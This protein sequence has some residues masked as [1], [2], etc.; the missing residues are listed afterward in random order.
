MGTCKFALSVLIVPEK[1]FRKMQLIS[2]SR[3]CVRYLFAVTMFKSYACHT[4]EQTVLSF[5]FLIIAMREIFWCSEESG[6]RERE[7]MTLSKT[8]QGQLPMEYNYVK[9]WSFGYLQ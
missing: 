7:Q 9:E 2:S 8:K 3:F 4:E 6:V 5:Q 1:L